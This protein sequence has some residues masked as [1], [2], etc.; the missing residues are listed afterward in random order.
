MALTFLDANSKRF[1]PL[2]GYK[3]HVESDPGPLSCGF[4]KVSG[5]SEESEVAEYR[6]GCDNV[7]MRKFPGL[8]S[9]E[10]I[11]LERGLSLE[12]SLLNWR[13]EVIKDINLTNA[14]NV[15]GLFSD[16]RRILVI[17]LYDRGSFTPARIWNCLEAWPCKLDDGELDASSS[18]VVIESAEFCHEGLFRFS[19]ATPEDLRDDSFARA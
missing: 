6:D 3:F 9:Y 7:T 5:L 10:N 18:D 13:E 12:R 1:D 17:T 14:P 4:N 2:R 15:D 16:F 19:V 11:V 8:V